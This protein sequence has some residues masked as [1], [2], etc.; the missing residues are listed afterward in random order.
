MSNSTTPV[1]DRWYVVAVS[2]KGSS[3]T[4]TLTGW[5]ITWSPVQA[6]ENLYT[7]VGKTASPVT[8]VLTLTYTG[9]S[10]GVSMVATALGGPVHPSTPL[11]GTHATAS[12]TGT[13]GTVTHA[14]YGHLDNA[15]LVAFRVTIATT[16]DVVPDGA[17][18]KLA[19][20]RTPH[21]ITMSRCNS[22]PTPARLLT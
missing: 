20:P 17:W 14:A 11:V 19:M 22:D 1:A 21:P 8:G 6:V 16:T 12:T 2:S 4:H 15:A 9:T 13:S 3:G 5:G 10:T 7:F 18:Q